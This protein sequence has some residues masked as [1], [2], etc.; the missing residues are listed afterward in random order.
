MA[1]AALA[2]SSVAFSDKKHRKVQLAMFAVVIATMFLAPHAEMASRLADFTSGTDY[3]FDEKGG[4]WAVSGP[5]RAPDARPPDFR[6]W[7]QRVSD[8][9]RG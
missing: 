3:N 5:R 7:H 4:R 2:V 6:G 1:L 9:Q 8:G